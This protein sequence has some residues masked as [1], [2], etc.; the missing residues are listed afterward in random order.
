MSYSIKN[1]YT[2]EVIREL[3]KTS[4]DAVPKILAKAENGRLAAKALSSYQR[5][6]IL[7]SVANQVAKQKDHFAKLITEESGKPISQAYREVRRCQN[8][9]EAC[10]A[11]VARCPGELLAFDSVQGEEN[12][13]G[14]FSY[15]PLGIILAIT[16]Y[17]DPL[18]LVAHK[19]GP[20]LA[21]GNAV[22]LKPSENTPSSALAL[23]QCFYRAGLARDALQVILGG[24]ELVQEILP[25]RQLR[26]LS[27]TGGVAVAELLCKQAGLKKLLMDLGGN[28]PVIVD[29]ACDINRA[30]RDAVDGA[31]YAAGQNCIGVQRVYIHRDIYDDYSA[32]F[33]RQAENIV[34]GDPLDRNTEMGP[35]IDV[36]RAQL[37]ES[38]V[39]HAVGEG[40]RVLCGHRREG[41]IYY[42][43]VL[44][45]VPDNHALL[46][47]EI[48]APVVV[49]SPYDD[50]DKVIAL[51]NKT[52]SMLHAA[53]FTD[54]IH[55][56][57]YIAEHVDAG[58]IM[59]NCSSDFRIDTMPFGG[60][61]YGS[62]G[63]EGVRFAIAEMS[64]TKVVCRTLV[65]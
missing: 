37:A 27:F 15:D 51:A 14:Y 48:F 41:A 1:P 52:E 24:A 26:M 13:R 53:V 31:F 36:G 8:T 46:T 16:P 6:E 64:Q 44:V 61:K 23:A 38:T 65:M 43:T 11:E 55:C 10:A 17:N 21:A 47:D 7:N 2:L 4:L 22:I 12:K 63:R 35:M 25:S 30:V 40:A 60:Y 58:G 57:D 34:V 9:L 42:P 19:L 50:I 62:L 28:A 33:T 3:E 29:K 32:Q 54:N 20:A 56:A 45:D 59:I 5:S 18:N 39:E 49:L